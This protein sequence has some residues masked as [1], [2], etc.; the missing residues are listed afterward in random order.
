MLQDDGKSPMNSDQIKMQQDILYEQFKTE[1]ADIFL[2]NYNN[3]V[4]LEIIKQLQPFDWKYEQ[5]NEEDDMFDM[6]KF[7]DEKVD[8]EMRQIVTLDNNSI[9]QGEWNKKTNQKDGRGIQIWPDGS[10]YDGFWKNDIA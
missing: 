1:K 10:R 8:R 2:P 3:H 7:Y 5:Q 9:Y 6:S 4:V